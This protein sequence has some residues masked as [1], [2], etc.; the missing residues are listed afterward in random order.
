MTQWQY[1][2]LPCI[3]KSKNFEEGLQNLIQTLNEMGV[4]GWEMVSGIEI[5]GVDWF[6]NI[7]SRDPMMFFKRPVR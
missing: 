1:C 4:D 6:N 2:A 3:V 5:V 7:N